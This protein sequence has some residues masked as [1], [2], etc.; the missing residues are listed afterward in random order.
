ML[1]YPNNQL[2]CQKLSATFFLGKKKET[3]SVELERN[4]IE[5]K[6]SKIIVQKK[7]DQLEEED[8]SIS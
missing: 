7:V 1:T 5:E 4:T 2:T 3:R 8:S 6:N